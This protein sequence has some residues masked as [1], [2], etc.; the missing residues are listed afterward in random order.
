MPASA[1]STHYWRAALTGTTTLCDAHPLALR[2]CP[3]LQSH[4]DWHK[5]AHFNSEHY[6]RNLVASSE[7]AELLVGGVRAVST[8]LEER[9]AF[10]HTFRGSLGTPLL[11]SQCGNTSCA[12]ATPGS[13]K[14]D[15]APTANRPHFTGRCSVGSPARYRGSTTITGHMVLSPCWR[16][17]GG[18]G[19]GKLE[20]TGG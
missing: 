15:P 5:Y 9:A 18:V 12:A 20:H 4:T 14:A 2:H 6:V 11:R 17:G 1:G 3:A 13:Y 19:S 8:S 7:D 10:L 16:W